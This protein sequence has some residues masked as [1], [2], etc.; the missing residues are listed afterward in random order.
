MAE[1]AKNAALPHCC[2][3][4]QSKKMPHHNKTPANKPSLTGIVMGLDQVKYT[5]PCLP[6]LIVTEQ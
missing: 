4:C 1:A 5:Y 3:V 2:L 6:A